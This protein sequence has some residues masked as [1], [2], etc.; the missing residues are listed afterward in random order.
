MPAA[1]PRRSPTLNARVKTRVR[2]EG[3]TVELSI[4]ATLGGPELRRSGKRVEWIPP[5]PLREPLAGADLDVTTALRSSRIRVYL[6]SLSDESEYLLPGD[7]EVAIDPDGELVRPALTAQLRIDAATAAAGHP[8]PEGDWEVRIVITVG[9]PSRRRAAPPP[10]AP[11]AAAG[12]P[13]WPSRRR[14]C[15]G[16]PRRWRRLPRSR[17]AGAARR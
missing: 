5:H 12:A 16:S 9:A 10:S 3:D 7:G 13:A 17:D 14:S 1:T 15:P 6:R 4:A 8:L 11:R 2:R